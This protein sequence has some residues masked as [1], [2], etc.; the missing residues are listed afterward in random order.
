MRMSVFPSDPGY[1]N[2]Q[3]FAEQE[4]VSIYLDGELIPCAVTADEELGMVVVYGEP[5][6]WD[7]DLPTIERKGVVKI[8]IDDQAKL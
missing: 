5:R 7:T 4:N 3:P 8:V 6:P 1:A 2:Y